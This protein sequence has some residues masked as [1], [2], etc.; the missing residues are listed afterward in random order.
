VP[1]CE[2]T[3][4]LRGHNCNV[5]AVVFRPNVVQDEKSPECALASCAADGSVKL[6]TMNRYIWWC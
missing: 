1:N 4:T 3:L 5:G 6:W 2:L